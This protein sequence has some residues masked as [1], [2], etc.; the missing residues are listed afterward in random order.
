MEAADYLQAFVL[1]LLYV[2]L[3]VFS[4]AGGCRPDYIFQTPGHLSVAM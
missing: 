3:E 1:P 2:L 4:S